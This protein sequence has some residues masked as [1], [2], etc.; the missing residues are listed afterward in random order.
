MVQ[1]KASGGS[2]RGDSRVQT[3]KK[4]GKTLT[5]SCLEGYPEITLRLAYDHGRNSRR[6]TL[7]DYP[8]TLQPF[9]RRRSSALPD[10][11]GGRGKPR[12]TAPHRATWL[13]PAANITRHSS[14]ET[15]GVGIW[16]DTDSYIVYADASRDE[17]ALRGVP[18]FPDLVAPG[19]IPNA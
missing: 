16:A 7:K 15:T 11:Y 4:E 8:A 9:A 17:R 12:V 19:A 5:R 18:Q 10:V 13:R 14:D 6:R 2:Q 1:P 3:P